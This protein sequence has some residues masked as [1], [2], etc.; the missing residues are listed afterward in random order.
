MPYLTSSDNGRLCLDLYVQPKASRTQV[1]GLHDNAIKIR[2]TSP[3][4]EGKANAQVTAFIA[5]LLK[6]PKSAVTLQ[7]GRQ[8]RCKRIE[9]TGINPDEVRR[10]LD[11]LL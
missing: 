7:S 4:V 3:P 2:I 9:I 10:I 1:A 6:I 5:K 11:P 8:S